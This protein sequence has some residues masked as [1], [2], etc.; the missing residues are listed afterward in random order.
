MFV[1]HENLILEQKK[2]SIHKLK[3]IVKQWSLRAVFFL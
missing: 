3:T 1:K 2:K